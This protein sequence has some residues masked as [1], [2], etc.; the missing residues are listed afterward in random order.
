M[1]K[2]EQWSLLLVAVEGQ[3]LMTIHTTF[4]KQFCIH[5]VGIS[6]AVNVLP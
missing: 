4:E 6:L 2:D 1:S 3:A 5:P